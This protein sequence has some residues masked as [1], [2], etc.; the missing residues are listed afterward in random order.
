VSINDNLEELEGIA[1]D[2]LFK[3]S[4]IELCDLHDII[5]RLHDDDAE[6]HAYAL[7]T[8]ML[9]KDGTISYMREDVMDAIMLELGQ[10][11]DGECPECGGVD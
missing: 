9:K 10:A 4:A 2:V 8:N 6:R 3:A 5:I 1:R 11:A 7:A